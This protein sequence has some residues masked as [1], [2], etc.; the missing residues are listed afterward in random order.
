M[1]TI[2]DVASVAGVS[3]ATVSRIMNGKGA[4]D[5]TTDRV[6]K[7]I[8]ELGYRPNSL[9]KSLSQKDSNLIALLV[10]NLINPFFCELAQ[11]IEVEAN[12][13]GYQIYLCN[14]ED[15]RDKV[16]YFIHNMIDQY[17]AGAIFS[18]LHITGE[19]LALLESNGIHTI[20][21]DRAQLK[22]PYSSLY[23][24]NQ[25]GGYL[26]TKHLLAMG[27]KRILMVAGFKENDG[28]SKGRFLGYTKALEEAGITFQ[29][30]IYGEYSMD[31]GYASVYAYLQK[32]SPI[33]AIFCSDDCMAIGAYRACHALGYV[34]GKDIKII[35]YDNISYCSFCNPPLSSVRQKKSE[36]S[37]HIIDE[38]DRLH[39]GTRS[40]QQYELEPELVLR[41]SSLGI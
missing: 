30:C 1:V 13:R 4:S 7:V 31:T 9:A 15:R 10:P 41:A 37:Q 39:K 11:S 34:I 12:K 35:G 25:K 22:H 24:N 33:D 26:A 3:K 20:T 5:K 21:M 36:M 23:V 17:V 8:A 18:S 32:H 6:N 2:K 16:D 38:I 27:A 40:I 19:D 28:S 14:S 29:Q